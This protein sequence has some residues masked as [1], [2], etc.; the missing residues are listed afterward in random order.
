LLPGRHRYGQRRLSQKYHHDGHQ[1]P[2][3]AIDEQLQIMGVDCDDIEAIIFTYLQWDHCYKMTRDPTHLVE[4]IY[5][6][7]HKLG[8]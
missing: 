5:P 8:I 1:D 3:T 2:G 4:P 6:I 7:P